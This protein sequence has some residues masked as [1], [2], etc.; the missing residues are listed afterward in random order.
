VRLGEW[1]LTQNPDCENVFVGRNICAPPAIDAVV[2]KSI[3]HSGY[4]PFDKNQLH[5]IAILKL[6]FPVE[7]NDFVRPICL[8]N[9]NEDFN[10]VEFI[11]GGF[12]KTENNDSSNLKLKT[13]VRSVSNFDCERI[14]ENYQLIT[15]MQ[16][17]ALGEKG[18]DS[19]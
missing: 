4:V 10:N 5:D 16:M 7:F 15:P 6:R 9:A 8:P 2:S 18:K 13:E 17:C 3:V 1:D 11:V 19:W 12:G 14:Y